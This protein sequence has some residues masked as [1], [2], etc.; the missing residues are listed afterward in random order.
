[1][2]AYPAAPAAA[3]PAAN[4]TPVGMAAA[5]FRYLVST[6][7][8]ALYM[9][10]KACLTLSGYSVGIAGIAVAVPVAAACTAE[11]SAEAAAS[12]SNVAVMV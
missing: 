7:I 2:A 6:E 1:M 3:A 11:L 4:K 5:P 10:V 12:A 9:L 8:S